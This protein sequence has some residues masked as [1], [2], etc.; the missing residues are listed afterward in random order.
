MTSNHAEVVVCGAGIAGISVAYHLAV[1]QG[2]KNIKLVDE[3]PPLSLTSDKST[4]CYRNWWPGPGDAMVSMMN[5]SIDLLEDLADQS[6]NV[7][8]MNR[9]GYLFATADPERIQ[10]YRSHGEEAERLGAGPLRVHDGSPGGPEY[11]PAALE[12]YMDDLTG[13]D[14]ILDH[15]LI[16]QHFP[17]L[18]PE[19]RAV[20]H[21]R[22]AGWFSAQQMGMYMLQQ[23]RQQGVE[24]I[25][26]RVEDIVLESGR[27]GQIKVG[28]PGTNLT[29]STRHFVNAAGPFIGN[30]ARMIGLELPVFAEQHAKVSIRDHK[31]VFPREAPLLIWSDDQLLPWREE[32]RR[33]FAED[34]ESR[35]LLDR[36]PAGV[37]A[38]PDG[39]EGS[40]ILLILWTYHLDPVAPTFPLEFDDAYPDIALRGLATMLPALKAYFDAPPKPYLDGGYY[41]KTQENRPLAGPLAVPGAWI[42]GALSGYGLMAA[43]ACGELLAKH[44]CGDTLPEYAPWFVLER[45]EDPEYQRLLAD[46]GRSG[47][48]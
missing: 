29:I 18:N 25:E 34:P 37:H 30:I 45:Y 38:R 19:T 13:A 43:P 1:H 17:Y 3:R 12:G 20:I 9:R 8:Q 21:A 10:D 39:P 27:V 6:G 4:E 40:P 5:R 7:F 26:G 31:G 32:E 36:F 44:I 16:M 48:L 33:F 35:F 22:R 47:Q 24:L 41:T 14:L 23:A 15:D 11:V 28:L 42:H 46:W 2:V